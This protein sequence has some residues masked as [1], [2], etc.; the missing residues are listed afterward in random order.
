[1]IR[2]QNYTIARLKCFT[3]LSSH[4]ASRCFREVTFVSRTLER[5]SGAFG[6]IWET[7]GAFWAWHGLNNSEDIISTAK[8]KPKFGD[9]FIVDLRVLYKL[10]S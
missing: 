10:R 4:K 6:S 7:P 5:D 3:Y 1:M 8:I 9:Q 2:I